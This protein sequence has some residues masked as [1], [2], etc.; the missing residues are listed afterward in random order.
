MIVEYFLGH[1]LT[2]NTSYMPGRLT[3][4]IGDELVIGYFYIGFA[5]FA[6]IYFHQQVENKKY[7]YLLLILL[8]AV[9]FLIGER[10]NFIKFFLTAFIFF[11]LPMN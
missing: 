7:N 5:L 6:F 10:S 9:S 1:N 8:V 2:G 3:S 4:F 11:L